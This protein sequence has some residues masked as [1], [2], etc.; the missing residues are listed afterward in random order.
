L[1]EGESY[2]VSMKHDVEY[3][4][5]PDGV[6]DETLTT[7]EVILTGFQTFTQGP[8]VWDGSTD[9]DW[10]TA[11]NWSTNSVPTTSD[12]VIIPG[13]LTNYP[14]VDENNAAFYYLTIQNGGTVEV[15]TGGVLTT[16]DY[17]ANTEPDIKIE[18]GGTLRVNDGQLN[19]GDDMKVEGLFEMNGGTVN[20]ND[21]FESRDGST[22][23]INGGTLS[24]GSYLN[25]G[26]GVSGSFDL[27]T[28]TVTM[29]TDFRVKNG[30]TAN[31]SGGSLTSTE[32]FEINDGGTLTVNN[33]TL[34]IK[35]HFDI[36][37]AF[38]LT[39]GTVTAVDDMR[40]YDGGTA[41][42]NGGD[43]TIGTGKN[44]EI[45]NGGYFTVN[46]SN[47]VVDE[48]IEIKDSGYFKVDAGTVTVGDN[49]YV[50]SGIS[51]EFELNGGTVTVTAD[52]RS[53]AGCIVDI[54]GGIL[55]IGADWELSTGEVSAKGNIELS[56]GTIDVTDDCVF[57]STDVI[58]TMDGDFQLIVGDNFRINDNGWTTITDGTITLTASKD[59]TCTL[60]SS[61]AL[62]YEIAAYNLTING[63]GDSFTLDANV[64]LEG[65]LILTAGT[66]NVSANN[67]GIN[68]EDNWTN[69]GGTL[70]PQAGTV[71]FDG[72][73]T[74]TIGGSSSTTFYNSTLNN[75]NGASLG[76]NITVNGTLTLT[77]GDIDLNGYTITLDPN[78][79]LSE[80][81]GNTLF[82]SSGLATITKDIGTPTTL[83]VGGLGTTITS[84]TNMGST[85]VTRGHAAQTTAGGTSINRYYDI[86]PTTNTGLDATLVFNYD[87]S[88]LNGNTEASLL[89]WKS[90]DG[91]ATWTNEGGILDVGNNTITLSNIG[92]FSRWTAAGT[93]TPTVTTTAISSIT[94]TS[95]TSGGNVTSD[96]GLAVTARGVCWSTSIDPTT[97]NSKTTD[98][99]GTGS[100]TSSITGLTPNTTYHVRAYAVNSAGTAYGSD[101][102][103]ITLTAPEMNLKQGATDIADGGSYDYGSHTSGT[104]ADVLFTIEN[105]GT[106]DLTLTTPLT[107]GGADA[108]EYS[109]QSQP[110]SP[111][112]AS[113][114]TTFTI[115]FSPTS[116]GAKTATI[117]IANNDSDE[118]PYDLTLNGNGTAWPNKTISG[119]VK[120]SNSNGMEGVSIA[121][122]NAGPTVTTNTIGYYTA[123]FGHGWNG[124]STV[125]KDTWNFTPPSYTY[126]SLTTNLINQNY[127]ATPK[128]V[129]ISGHIRD[130]DNV[131]IEGFEVVFNNGG[132]T[133]TTSTSGH[134]STSVSYGWSGT[135]T[136]TKDGWTCTPV[137]YTYPAVTTDQINKDYTCAEIALGLEDYI[138]SLPE[139]FTILPAFPNPFN[140]ITTIRYGLDSDSKVNITIYDITGQLITTL[141]NAE[142]I[143]GWHSIVWNG[144]GQNQQQM[145]AGIYLS[146]IIA[147]NEVRTSKIMFLK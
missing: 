145:P 134:Y 64:D 141:L 110:S 109:I 69:N 144:T 122:S 100:Y 1:V 16:S 113:G 59:G 55:N 2:T 53:L 131:G 66:L 37:G 36:T 135:A 146:R 57:S 9:T 10:A 25:V 139:K 3:V 114:T 48:D 82:G 32:D 129:Q 127:I 26:E 5:A 81:T 84:G 61:D 70:T 143:Q 54:N 62:L 78:A 45:Y 35:D 92:S 24:V 12:Y 63:S 43:L 4:S 137:N 49:L 58:G 15:E 106:A 7:S 8:I 14:S 29:G 128:N 99:T 101:K 119:Y 21:Y 120:D 105:T 124:S 118:N 98:G 27:S 60:Q 89:L 85:I 103:F 65:G 71:T 56:G 19:C 97:A 34:S 76:Q 87:E 80:T 44:I 31:V 33:G 17:V 47:V 138:S 136:A 52:F 6:E 104:N 28:G 73:A 96:G 125:T 93:T 41:N 115:R 95:A 86:T 140:P 132:A 68:L 108:G 94:S 18:S 83:D 111:I 46:G 90:T 130:G 75:S 117:A 133:V 88:E 142:Q 13:S 22:T 51:G 50:G 74:Q 72:S 79:L 107:L 11:A 91:G 40:I 23:D 38:I 126:P 121:F 30:A 39:S 42:A 67:Y 102:S 147:G 123:S 112:A 77:G 116:V 20:V